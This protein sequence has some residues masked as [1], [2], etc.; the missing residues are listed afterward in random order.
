MTA[1]E[2]AAGAAMWLITGLAMVFLMAPLLTDLQ[3]REDESPGGAAR[4]GDLRQA[5][6]G[7]SPA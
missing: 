7:R 3:K 6:G 5:L 4:E 2:R 1:T